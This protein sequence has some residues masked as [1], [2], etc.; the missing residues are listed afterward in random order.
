MPAL[1]ACCAEYLLAS[2]YAAALVTVP[3]KGWG[4]CTRSGLKHS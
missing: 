1:P 3:P 4:L 2:I